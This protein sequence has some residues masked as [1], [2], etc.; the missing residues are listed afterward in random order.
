MLV[1]SYPPS[2]IVVKIADFGCAK[3][4]VGTRLR[5]SV[6][7]DGY[8]APEI[9][10][11]GHAETSVY[12]FK[13]DI[14]SLGCLLYTIITGEPPLQ[15]FRAYIAYTNSG[16]PFP[17]EQL[18]EQSLNGAGIE[19]I[20]SL[21]APLPEDRFTADQALKHRWLIGSGE[22]MHVGCE[23]NVVTELGAEDSTLLKLGGITLTNFQCFP[24]STPFESAQL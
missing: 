17:S 4:A 12:S 5:S 24:L 14:W 19:F 6:G 1:I 21:M 23:H 15:E 9:W 10:G 20:M 2:P 3:Y 22:V 11:Y 18:I 8:I 13:V 16:G 7:T